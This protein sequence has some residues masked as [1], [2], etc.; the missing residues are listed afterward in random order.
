MSKTINYNNE[1]SKNFNEDQ[2][3]NSGNIVIEVD[4]YLAVGSFDH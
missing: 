3:I 1:E 4:S 2:Y